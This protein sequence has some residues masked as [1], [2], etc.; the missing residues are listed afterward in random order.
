MKDLEALS[1]TGCEVSDGKDNSDLMSAT[2]TVAT[3]AT[4]STKK[5]KKDDEESMDGSTKLAI[6]ICNNPRMPKVMWQDEKEESSSMQNFRR[7]EEIVNGGSDTVQHI[8][9]SCDETEI[10]A[11][12]ITATTTAKQSSDLLYFRS[13]YGPT[14]NP[15]CFF[16]PADCYSFLSLYGPLKNPKYFFFGLMVFAF[17]ITFLLLMVVSVIDKRWSSQSDVDN[18]DAGIDGFTGMIAQFVPAQNSPLIRGTQIIAILAYVIFADSSLH[19][20]ATSVE[21][22][23]SFSKR[24]ETDKI[25]CI[26]FLC[27]LRFT[28]GILAIVVTLVLILTSQ[29]VIDIIINFTAINFISA[30]D[31]AAFGLAQWGKYGPEL[32]EQA[33]AIK[34]LPLPRCMSR[35]NKHIRYRYTVV[36]IAAIL[37]IAIGCVIYFQEKGSRW[38]TG[39]LRV[40]IGE[41]DFQSYNGCY[42]KNDKAIG[43]WKGFRRKIYESFD[44]ND[45]SARFGYCMK[46]RR[47]LLF[48]GD[49][50]NVCDYYNGTEALAHSAKTDSFDISTSFGESWYSSGNKPLEVYF[51]EHE[52][53]EDMRKHCGSFLKDGNCDLVFNNLAYEYDK[54][55]CCSS[56]CTG[57]SCGIEAL[58]NAFGSVN[59]FGDGFPDCKDPSMVPVTI[60]LSNFSSS[61]DPEL[62]NLSDDNLRFI[63]DHVPNFWKFDPVDILL[64]LTCD[65]KRVLKI[66]VDK[67]MTNKT[68]TVMVKDG[69][70]CTMMIEKKQ[71][72]NQVGMITLSGFSTTQFI[73]EMQNL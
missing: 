12:L 36:P 60:R 72:L 48:K 31:N 16:Y 1:Y 56:T 23:P 20:V 8:K 5:K 44:D 52:N 18:P 42:E 65:G 37:I 33:I 54:G 69:A 30:L 38:S 2:S 64:L 28:Q 15:K 32:Q 68:E 29:T 14:E 71:A 63:D 43:R 47:W 46:E 49:G 66:Y 51:A 73:T 6:D 24:T 59:T 35:K 58:G 17:Q 19:D 39:I 41:A 50:N 10:D 34:T 22:F 70:D 26:V 55:D 45:N 3:V 61:R 7:I 25:G 27:A 53:E 40:Q 21:T 11:S 4:V 67:T 57:L 13:L 9:T 62:L